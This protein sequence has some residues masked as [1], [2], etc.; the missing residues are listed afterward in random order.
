[1]QDQENLRALYTQATE[2]HGAGRFDEALT[3]YERLLDARPR[4]A[5][6]L[7]LKGLAQYQ[8]GDAHSAE[9]TM[10]IGLEIDGAN[11]NHHCNFGAVLA[12]LGKTDKA[13]KAIKKA[14]ELDPGNP[15]ALSNL[16]ALTQ[17]TG[18][19]DEAEQTIRQALE[20]R[21]D[22]P[23]ALN[24][25]GSILR[26]KGEPTQ[27][28][29]AFRKALAINGDLLEAHVNLVNLLITE[30]RTEEALQQAQTALE[31]M[32][33]HAET[34]N[35]FGLALL[36][37][38]AISEAEDV[39][40]KAIEAN[41]NHVHAL[42][43]LGV[44]QK[45]QG[46]IDEAAR[47]FLS[48]RKAG[49][50]SPE[51]NA[52]LAEIMLEMN[53]TSDALATIK[54]ALMMNPGYT[55]GWQLM[56]EILRKQGLLGEAIATWEKL[57]TLAPPTAETLFSIASSLAKSG[58]SSKALEY[59]RRAHEAAPDNAT[60]YS[61]LLM[62]LHY[63]PGPDRQEIFDAHLDWAEKYAGETPPRPAITNPSPDR[64]L[65]IGFVSSDFRFHA[66]TFF[67]LGVLKTWKRDAW[68]IHLYSS[69]Q[70]PDH[71]TAEFE[72]AADKWIDIAKLSDEEAA[73]QI[74]GD[75]IDILID[76]AGHTKGN[77]LGVF[78][79]RPAPLQVCWFDYVDTTGL[80]VMDYWIGD[81]HQ[82][83]EDE[84]RYY[85]EKVLRLPNDYICYSPPEDAPAVSSSAYEKKN[86]I[87]LGCFNTAYKISEDA[88]SAWV[89]ILKALPEA[90]LLINTP[91]MAI[92]YV[93]ERYTG[94][95]TGQGIDHRRITFGTGGDHN[96]FLGQ[97]EEIDIALDPFPYSGGLNTCEALFMGVPV[98]TFPGDRFCSR[99]AT[100]HLHACGHPELVAKNK[101]DYVA[102]VIELANDPKRLKTYRRQLREDVLNSP[103]TDTEGFI[104]AFT[105][106]LR[107]I[108]RDACSENL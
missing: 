75:D 22:D 60:V 6:I 5:N 94:L 66:M 108:W 76:M 87:T 47:A 20:N 32:P 103:L 14:L 15:E 55:R 2:H 50:A 96:T 44:A 10:F 21:P 11:P 46:K 95:L 41:P 18:R 91:E 67:F 57:L 90:N 43:N 35:A 27:A 33:D 51:V 63:A 106:T 53:K 85:T 89:E 25:L 74:K 16:S 54:Q 17:R 65:K 31:I 100:A 36:K 4:D 84:D 102:K 58:D 9:E 48:A 104:Q 29:E 8:S 37:T 39:L 42:N 98:V 26:D 40:T 64:K 101:Q 24:N 99:H 83:P 68:H 23:S 71:Y 30:E 80:E 70:T 62:A 79:Q 82:N 105:D 49:G 92:P 28:E 88:I 38:G 61:N 73:A 52:N 59:Y 7:H 72:A 34:L 13:V 3:L 107:T 86:A 19:L 81:V 77:R 56:G 93:R 12:A 78:T 69:V 97:Y 45:K 1:M